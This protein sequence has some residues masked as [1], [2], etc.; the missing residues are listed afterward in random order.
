MN[1]KINILKEEV[2]SA[3][4]YSLKK[5]VFEYEEPGK[6]KQTQTREVFDRGNGAAILLYDLQRGTILLT[7][8]FRL[9]TY[10]NGNPDGM[11]IEACAGILEQESPK[12]CIIRETREE[13]GYHIADVQKVYELYVTPGAVTELMHLFVAE[14]TPEMKRSKGGGL[15]EENEN[16]ENVEL[17]F[18]KALEMVRNGKIRDAK[19]VVL[20][21]YAQLNI[22]S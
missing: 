13:T 1:P 8:Q 6:E 15:K 19:T 7:R 17:E 2:L 18:S 12:D 9:P 10:V 21:Q 5:F 20:V 3:Q 11:L 4:K 14:Y 22:F 16:I